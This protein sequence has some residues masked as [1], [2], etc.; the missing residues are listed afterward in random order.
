V[1]TNRNLVSLQRVKR[2]KAFCACLVRQTSG[3]DPRY[4]ASRRFNAGQSQEVVG[5][6]DSS[7]S[8]ALAMS[9][10]LSQELRTT[11]WKHWNKSDKKLPSEQFYKEKMEGIINHL[12][13]L[14]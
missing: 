1:V 5:S 6:S 12:K 8:V 11:I 2:Y 14:L 3:F 7:F 9:Q 4:T 10:A 13:E